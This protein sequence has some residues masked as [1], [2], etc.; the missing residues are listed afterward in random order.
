MVALATF[1]PDSRTIDALARLHGVVTV[2]Q[3]ANPIGGLMRLFL[4]AGDAPPVSLSVDYHDVVFKFEC[5]SIVADASPRASFSDAHQITLITE[6][7]TIKCLFC[8]EWERP[9]LPGEVPPH[10]EQ[11]TR[12]RGTREKISSDASAVCVSMIGIAFWNVVQ[13]KAIA[14]IVSDDDNDPGTMRICEKPEE[15]EVTISE[16]EKVSVDEVGGWT[17]QLEQLR[18]SLAS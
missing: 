16:S 6:W 5:F 13:D 10:F 8:F 7:H 2:L 17:L 1:L 12:K 4:K 11:I 3:P 9:A 15:I 14:A 18:R